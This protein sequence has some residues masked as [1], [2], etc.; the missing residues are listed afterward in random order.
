MIAIVP[1]NLE[2]DFMFFLLGFGGMVSG[3]KPES[4]VLHSKT[5]VLIRAFRRSCWFGLCFP[6]LTWV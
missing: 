5:K 2:G 3:G 6:P 4:D 1:N